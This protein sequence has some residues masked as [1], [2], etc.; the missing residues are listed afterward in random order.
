MQDRSVPMWLPGIHAYAEK[1]VPAGEALHL[2]VSSDV[3]YRLSVVQLGHNL[4]GPEGDTLIQ[5]LGEFPA[6]LQPIFPGSYAV[7]D[8]S[9]P[10]DLT[11][12]AL[13]LECWVRPWRLEGR[14]GII[15]Q[16]SVPDA[17]G[18]GLFIDDGLP[19]VYFGDGAFVDAQFRRGKTLLEFHRWH[20][21]AAVWDGSAVK[22]WVDGQLDGRW[23]FAGPLRP[24]SAPLHL[25]AYGE[26]GMTVGLLDGDIAMP[27]IYGSALN[28]ESILERFEARALHAPY[29]L[30]D[31]LACWPLAEERGASLADIGPQGRH[32][33]IVNHATWM[34]G[35]PGFDG[36]AVP[37]Y[38]AYDPKTDP[39]RGH[40][41]RFASDDLYDCGWEAT[42]RCQIP[43]DAKSGLYVGRFWFG[44]RFEK[45]YDV[46]FV[47]RKPASRAAAP[48]L[49]LCASNTWLAYNATPFASGYQTT[50]PR[51]EWATTA[52][53]PEDPPYPPAYSCYRNHRYGQPTYQ[54]GLRM[55]WP[56][57]GP[58]VLYSKMHEGYSHLARADRA[59]HIWLDQQ[60]YR[61]DVI[62]DSD[63]H[64]DPSLL[65]EYKVLFINGHS[66]YWSIPMY[67]ELEHFLQRGGNAIVL[68]GNSL[69][70]R[71]SFD[72]DLAV[73]ECRKEGDASIGGRQYAT[74]GEAFHSDDGLRGSLMREC[75]FPAYRLVGLESV[76]YWNAVDER[77]Y[78]CMLP[79]HFLLTTPES[80]DL[81]PGDPLAHGQIG[82]EWDVRISQAQMF[83]AALPEGA[84]AL[85][86]PQGIVTLAECRAAAS[87][88]VWDYFMRPVKTEH[89]V[90]S[91]MIYWERPDGGRVFHA[92]FI[93]AGALL[94]RD[95]RFSTIMRNVLHHFTR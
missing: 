27:I 36:A 77:D 87:D 10:A 81:R 68:S 35:G 8:S 39:Q 60:D 15:T 56:T 33:R 26:N 91:H 12:T 62:A 16:F 57:A 6:S 95:R 76:G 3:P 20:H 22:L 2:R 21:L 34:I 54:M 45:L 51:Q 11:L 37:R 28:Q 65:D 59:A 40:G 92:G 17:C 41:L 90:V 25:G 75:G 93:G 1:S 69:F 74:L 63:L 38:G 53:M 29:F 67:E 58:Y 64:R 19:A 9:L 4:D 73:M 50:E 88:S 85:A 55:P 5:D 48:I 49:M 72:D 30:D 42:H 31:V 70:W 44:E 94:L 86:E 24:G 82:H 32:A 71:V 46:L 52:G 80:L 14:Q 47:V 83:G 84:A 7:V 13:T 66:E 79:E 18:F 89:S 23:P 78:R 61:Y 43:A